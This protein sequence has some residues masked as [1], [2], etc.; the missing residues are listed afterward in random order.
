MGRLCRQERGGL[1]HGRKQGRN[2][3]QFLVFVFTAF[4]LLRQ[5][6]CQKEEKG[7]ALSLVLGFGFQ[8][9]KQLSQRRKRHLWVWDGTLTPELGRI[10]MRRSWGASRRPGKHTPTHYSTGKVKVKVAQLCLTLYDPIDCS[11]PGTSVHGILQVRILEWLLCPWGDLPNPGIEPRSPAL[12][13]DSLPA[14]PPG[15]CKNTG[16]GNLS[17][18]QG[19]FLTQESNWGLLHCRRILS[20]LS[21]QGSSRYLE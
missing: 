6:S 16:V 4:R 20:Q 14:E 2:Y 21:Y 19:I 5:L 15:K 9:L 10:S 8:E 12:Q 1:L 11:L 13:A 18:L 7:K 17:L 3:T